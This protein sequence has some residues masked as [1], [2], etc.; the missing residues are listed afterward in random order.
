M[1]LLSK[2]LFGDG[3]ELSV[4]PVEDNEEKKKEQQRLKNLGLSK[5]EIDLVTNEGWDETSFEE[6]DDD[7]EYEDDDYY[8][9]DD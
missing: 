5:E 4:T 8:G 3:V 6:Y 7:D 9:E 1:G 2:L